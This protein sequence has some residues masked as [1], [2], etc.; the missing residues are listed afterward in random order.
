MVE[1]RGKYQA[2]IAALL[3]LAAVPDADAQARV[4]YALELKIAKAHASI[5]DS[6]DIHKA[7]NAW[8]LADFAKQAPGLDWNA[9]FKAA[10][11]DGQAVLDAWQPHAVAGLSKLVAS[12]PL[13]AWKSWLAFHAIDRNVAFLPQ[14]YYDLSFGFYGT[15]MQ[16]TPQQRDRW[17]RALALVGGDLGDA[18]GKAYVAKYFPASSREHIQQ[19]VANLLAVFPSASIVSTG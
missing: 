9:F 12:E 18:V 16:G 6:Q 11:L 7:N 4:V 13:A 1:L 17:K 3:K 10:G 5:T 15:A 2:Y 14:A 19:L 8:P